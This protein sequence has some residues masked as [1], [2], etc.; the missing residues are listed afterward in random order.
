MTSEPDQSAPGGHEPRLRAFYAGRRVCVTG[1]AG[2][3]GGHLARALLD[4]GAEV[5]VIDDCSNADAAGPAELLDRYPTAFRFI[6]AS[7]LEP[8]A[9]ADAVD[10]CGTV[11]HEAA[12]VSV[13]RSLEE[14]DRCMLV[15]AVGTERVA[16]AARLAGAARMVYAASSSAYGDTDELPKREDMPPN[17]LSPYAAAKLAG[18]QVVRAWASSWE[19]DGVSLR[20]FNVFGAGQPGDSPYSAV[21]AKFAAQIA[22][23]E[24]VTIF[25]DGEQ[26][27]DMTHVSNAVLANLLAGAAPHPLDGAV[28]NVGCG[29]RTTINTLFRRIAALLGREHATATHAEP[30]AGDVRHSLADLTSIR[31][32]LG[33]EPVTTLDEGL[34]LT[35]ADPPERTP[36][37]VIGR[38][39]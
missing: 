27:R 11:F 8:E 17:C 4:L 35:L 13:P 20:Y 32:A 26:T 30:R 38:V 23:D 37:G 15:N 24:P 7:I 29:E 34:R 25:G 21:V 5:S 39:G 9:L 1:G 6:H 31:T 12:M 18:E 19:L 33:Y 36:R 3:I 14:P 22:A 16:E 10:R 28:L 2:F